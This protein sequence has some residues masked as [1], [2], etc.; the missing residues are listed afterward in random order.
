MQDEFAIW[1]PPEE[2][3]LE[4]AGE[5]ESGPENHPHL[6]GVLKFKI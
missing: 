6:I 1:M 2:E 5:E 4:N 3:Q